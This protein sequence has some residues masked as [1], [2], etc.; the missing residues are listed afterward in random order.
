MPRR[1]SQV[2]GF[3]VFRV[4][5]LLSH[6]K[7]DFDCTSVKVLLLLVIFC[8]STFPN[9]HCKLMSKMLFTKLLFSLLKGQLFEV[10]MT[11][12]S[13]LH[14][15]FSG[16]AFCFWKRKKW[17][18]ESKKPLRKSSVVKKVYVIYVH[19]VNLHESISSMSTVYFCEQFSCFF[20]TSQQSDFG[21]QKFA[22]IFVSQKLLFTL[23]IK[24]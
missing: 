17:T 22:V 21:L 16:F 1:L 9:F 12:F 7:A 13:L 10:S 4:E 15:Y 18:P 24:C 5:N 20:V 19:F 11:I 23:I 3:F 2:N 8:L 14:A 6:G